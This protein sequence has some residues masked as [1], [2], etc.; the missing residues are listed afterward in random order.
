M[1]SRE[2]LLS[3]LAAFFSLIVPTRASDTFPPLSTLIERVVARDNANKKA[4]QSM[5]YHQT[6]KTERL[7]EHDQVIRRQELQM[8]VR[9]GTAQE[10]QVISEKGDNLPANPDEAA[11]QAQGHKMQKQKIDFALKDIVNRFTVTLAG[12]DTLQN[13]PVYVLT[14]EPKPDQPYRNQTEK[15]LN[16]LHGRIWISA[17]DYSVLRTEATLAKPVEVAWIFAQI[18]ALNFHYE[19]NNT[20]GG[21]GPAHIQTS[22]E[23]DAPFIKIRQ[24][25]TIDMTQFKPRPNL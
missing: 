8:I 22:V 23:V 1:T 12:T 11:L 24:Q 16:Q 25:M 7:D 21:M 2:L 10:L 3:M 5:E 9:P 18:S 14:F 6:L 4:L 19:L 13:E 17:R 20:T 15:V